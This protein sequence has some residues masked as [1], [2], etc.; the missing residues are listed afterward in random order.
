MLFVT[1]ENVVNIQRKHTKLCAPTEQKQCS[2][3]KRDF[4]FF[5][6]FLKEFWFVGFYQKI[7]VIYQEKNKILQNRGLLSSFL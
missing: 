2:R 6:F 1:R 7:T 4:F 3:G 5:F